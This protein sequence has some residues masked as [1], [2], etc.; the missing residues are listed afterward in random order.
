MSAG[1]SAWV[2][3]CA[4][5]NMW[6][7]VVDRYRCSPMSTSRFA[8]MMAVDGEVIL[9]EAALAGRRRRCGR[10]STRWSGSSRSIGSPATVR[11]R[12]PTASPGTCS[13][14][15]GFTGNR[16]VVLR[17]A[18]LVPRPGD[19]HPGRDPDHAVDADDRGRP[20]GRRAAG[21]G[22]GCRPTS[23]SASPMTT[24]AFYDPFHGPERLDRRRRG[25]A[26]PTGHGRAERPGATTSS[27]PP[28]NRD[29]VI[30]MLNNLQ[31]SCSPAVPTP[32]A[33]AS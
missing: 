3:R 32:S 11:R 26:V 31:G 1:L 16:I 15:S 18:E 23:S 27:P 10:D 24:D 33:S 20:P 29:I 2:A 22:S 12:R 30:R 13:T 14:R 5:G 19:R 9:D 8:T 6:R 4:P 25:R 28:P 7:N 17:L 21:R